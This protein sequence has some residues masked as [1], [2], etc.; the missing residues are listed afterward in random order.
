MILILILVLLPYIKAPIDT[1]AWALWITHYYDMNREILSVCTVHAY[2]HARYGWSRRRRRRSK[3]RRRQRRRN[4]SKTRL[5]ERRSEETNNR[6]NQRAFRITG[7]KTLPSLSLPS[8]K[9]CAQT[10]IPYHTRPYH[11]RFYII[12]TCMHDACAYCIHFRSCF[13]PVHINHSIALAYTHSPS[14]SISI[15]CLLSL[16]LRHTFTHIHTDAHWHTHTHA[17]FWGV[18]KARQQ[19][20]H[21]FFLVLLRHSVWFEVF[22]PLF[23][24]T[25]RRCHSISIRFAFVYAVHFIFS[26]LFSFTWFYCFFD[27]DVCR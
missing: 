13:S 2:K 20:F 1:H 23:P 17:P 9:F 19:C 7:I 18:K 15:S 5:N 24:T 11:E 22:F 3:R 10:C 14:L 25:T 12:H 21:H 16:S 4:R 27:T 6:T 8:I 26:S